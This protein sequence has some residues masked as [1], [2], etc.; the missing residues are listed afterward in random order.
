MAPEQTPGSQKN[1]ALESLRGVASVGVLIWHSLLAFFPGRTGILVVSDH[2]WNTQAWFVLINGPGWVTFFF[3]LSGY[4]LTRACLVTGDPAPV[5]RNALKRWPRLAVPVLLTVI[6]SWALYD[7]GAYRFPEAG[8]LDGSPWLAIGGGMRPPSSPDLW[9]AVS[10]GGF[11]TFFKGNVSFDSTL[12]TMNI[13]FF[14]SFIAFGLALLLLAV[15]QVAARAYLVAIA[16]VA[17]F[18]AHPYYVAFPAGVALA[19]FLPRRRAAGWPVLLA[20]PFAVAGLFLLGYSGVQEGAFGFM[21][22][23]WPQALA[24]DDVNTLGAFLLIAGTEQSALLH[25][26]LSHRWGVFLGRLSFPLYLV[27]VP[28]ICSAGVAVYLG[29]HPNPA[30]RAPRLMACAVGAAAAFAAACPLMWANE[31]WIRQLNRWKS[32]PSA[33]V[34]KARYAANL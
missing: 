17:C 20:M 30:A 18:F 10:E 8:R 34:P 6:A 14:G 15:R 28:V 4:V 22:G 29:M 3:V 11:M 32:W 12:W 23:W 7:V 1:Y 21:A 13:E 26:A 27:H 31:W 16:L 25:R 9:E 19:A 24:A 2:A 5:V 33:N